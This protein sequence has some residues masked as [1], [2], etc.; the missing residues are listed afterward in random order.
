MFNFKQ[1][2][3]G[4]RGNDGTKD[5]EIMVAL[6]HLNKVYRTLE[7][8]LINCEINL[9]LTCSA[10]CF[11]VANHVKNQVPTFTITDPKLYVLV[12]ALLSQ[13]NAA[14]EISF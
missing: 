6:K 5:V 7:M 14:I 1:K 2:I 13:D 9:I 11:V 3:T 4:Q 12:V 8:P 10:N